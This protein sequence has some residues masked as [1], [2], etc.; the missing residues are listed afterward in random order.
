MESQELLGACA[1]KEMGRG[2]EGKSLRVYGAQWWIGGTAD[3]NV[4]T[5][6]R[7]LNPRARKPV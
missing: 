1:R 2:W 5:Y 3:G 7:M 4:R 6:N